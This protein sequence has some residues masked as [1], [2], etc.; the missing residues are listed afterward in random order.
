VITRQPFLIIPHI[1]VNLGAMNIFVSVNGNYKRPYN[2]EKKPQ[3]E[4]I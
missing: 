4:I 2:E 1:K 3:N